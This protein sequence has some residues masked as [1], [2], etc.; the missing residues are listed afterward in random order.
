MLNSSP[1]EPSS[2]D[3]D[4]IPVDQVNLSATIMEWRDQTTSAFNEG[5]C[6]V[7]RHRHIYGVR[8]QDLGFR[9]DSLEVLARPAAICFDG[10]C[11]VLLPGAKL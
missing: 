1:V 8:V 2:K 5:L 4:L 9:V 7:S 10:V 11:S 3:A 6:L